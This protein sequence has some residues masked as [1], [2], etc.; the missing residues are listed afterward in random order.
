M[1]YVRTSEQAVFK[2][3]ELSDRA[4][5]KAR[6]WWRDCENADGCDLSCNYEDFATCA[7]ILGIDLRTRPVKLMSGATR[8]DPC[9]WWSG[10]SSQN[11]G[12]CLEGSY[13]YAK[14]AAKKIREHAP[15]D[16]ELH[17]I[18]DELFALQRK[19]FYR[20]E[21]RA[22]HRGHYY[23]SGC[24]QIDVW[25]SEGDATRDEDDALAQL[26]RDFAD[27]VYC[28]LEKDYE[29]RMADEQVDENIR[30][31]EYDFDEDGGLL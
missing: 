23:H 24:M 11:D 21:A 8:Y 31:N 22:T 14:G 19:A 16:K 25:R 10:F 4:K 1:P 7:S 15:E 18:A 5:E 3:A 30:A 9:I 27:W 12:A 2:F 28:Q 20:L 17:R 13:A 26:L 29:W 6:D